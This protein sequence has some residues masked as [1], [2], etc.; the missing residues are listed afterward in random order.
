MSL[1]LNAPV[2]VVLDR[3]TEVSTT[4]SGKRFFAA[5]FKAGLFGRPVRRAFFGTPSDDG[6]T[7]KWERVSPEDLMPLVGQDF[8]G[9]ISVE[10]VAVEPVEFADKTTGEVRT[11]T[12]ISVVKLADETTEAATKIYGHTLRSTRPIVAAGFHIVGGDGAV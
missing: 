10:A 9:Q 1:A 2:R 5:F 3:I 11:V 12:S 6:S 7:T 8:A 4:N